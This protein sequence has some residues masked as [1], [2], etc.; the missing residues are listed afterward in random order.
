MI[1]K[2]PFLM[3]FLYFGSPPTLENKL[4][5]CTVCENRVP[6]IFRRK[7]YFSEKWTKQDPPGR[8][9]NKKKTV[10]TPPGDPLKTHSKKHEKY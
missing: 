8:P 10:K 5:R 4:K 7:L 6:A 2:K 9:K 3:F 1:S